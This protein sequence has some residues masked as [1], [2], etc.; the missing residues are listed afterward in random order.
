MRLFIE[1]GLTF[2]QTM[3]VINVRKFSIFYGEWPTLSVCLSGTLSKDESVSLCCQERFWIGVLVFF[4]RNTLK[5]PVYLSVCQ[6]HFWK[7]V[8]VF[9]SARNASKAEKSVSLPR[10][11]LKKV[12][13][14]R[15]TLEKVSQSI[16]GQEH[17]WNAYTYVSLVRNTVNGV[18]VCLSVRN[19][20]KELSKRWCFERGNR[21]HKYGLVDEDNCI[22]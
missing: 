2:C 6:E 14:C 1:K 8:L 4:V 10:T 5:K 15:N 13:V 11:F 16:C 12:S 9:L 17:F 22:A 21:E 20:L 3:N 19:A 18:S 7:V